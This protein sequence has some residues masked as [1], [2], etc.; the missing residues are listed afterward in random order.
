V[1]VGL[2]RKRGPNAGRL[3]PLDRLQGVWT[4][5]Y[6]IG[7]ELQAER[8]PDQ[9]QARARA[10]VIMRQWA[11]VEVDAI[12]GELDLLSGADDLVYLRA[13]RAICERIELAR[14]IDAGVY[15]QA[16]TSL[17]E[18]IILRADGTQLDGDTEPVA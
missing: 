12:V 1:P 9:A 4:L 10:A 15:D 18:T 3:P 14:K 16:T 17:G 6:G 13:C 8:W 5:H 11:Q 2:G 7:T